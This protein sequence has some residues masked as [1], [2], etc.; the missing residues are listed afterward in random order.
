M[1]YL[2]FLIMF[3]GGF[4]AA[5]ASTTGAFVILAITAFTAGMY[6]DIRDV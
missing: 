6:Q 1:I 5:T 2:I 4:L 3:I